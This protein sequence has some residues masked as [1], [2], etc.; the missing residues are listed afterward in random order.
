MARPGGNTTG[1]S[2]L[3]SELDAKRLQL[4]HEL[5]PQAARIGILADPTTFRPDRSS[6]RPR[7]RL[8][9]S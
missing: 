3:A 1:I 7:W 2:I 9:S 4:L 5:V 8:G 6:K